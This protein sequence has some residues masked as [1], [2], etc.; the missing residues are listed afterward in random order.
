MSS[1]PT[2][3]AW[4]A[5]ECR[6]P[7][8]WKCYRDDPP[9]RVAVGQE[10]WATNESPVEW[11]N[12]NCTAGTVVGFE[13]GTKNPWPRV[14]AGS[15]PAKVFAF[16]STSQ[17]V[18]RNGEYTGE[19]VGLGQKVWVAT[20]DS[21]LTQQWM[22]GE[23]VSFEPTLGSNPWPLVA[24]GDLTAGN[25][26]DEDAGDGD[27]EAQKK[28]QEE[29]REAEQWSASDPSATARAWPVVDAK[30]A[31]TVTLGQHVWVNA[32]TGEH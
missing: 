17:V 10:V 7:R 12:T 18:L 26:D 1:C 30:S 15:G 9:P 29:R 2:W 4:T 22:R 16:V 23:V 11:R 14:K 21:D 5:E 27:Q 8:E 24:I 25:D 28:A 31:P 32:Q 13:P 6:T 19:A 20:S 3:V